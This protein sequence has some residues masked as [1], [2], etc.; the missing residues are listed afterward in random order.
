MSDDIKSIIERYEAVAKEMHLTL[1]VIERIKLDSQH[2]SEIHQFLE[3]FADKEEFVGF[4]KEI[5]EKLFF[6]KDELTTKEAAMY[7][8][9][10]VSTLYKKTM[11]NEIPFY[12]PSS[13]H[14]Y[15]KRQELSQWMLQNRNATNEEMQAEASLSDLTNM[16]APKRSKRQTIKKKESQ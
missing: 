3:Q 11:N 15:F 8:G 6:L 16:F 9:M 5:K 10:S 1:E 4:I 12:R 14:L 2:I 13:R 7:L